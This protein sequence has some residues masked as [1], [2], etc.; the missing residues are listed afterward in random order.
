M[1]SLWNAAGFI[2]RRCRCH[3]LTISLIILP[4]S[5]ADIDFASH[6]FSYKPILTP[7]SVQR[8]LLLSFLAYVAY[9]AS[10]YPNGFPMHVLQSS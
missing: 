10:P 6:T 4:I 5:V 8:T 2:A 7:I 9:F 1:Y 3:A